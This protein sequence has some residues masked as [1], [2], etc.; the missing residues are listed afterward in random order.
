MPPNPGMLDRNIP[1]RVGWLQN[2]LSPTFLPPTVTGPLDATTAATMIASSRNTDAL[3]SRV[4]EASRRVMRPVLANLTP[5]QVR[6]IDASTVEFIEGRKSLNDLLAE[7]PVLAGEAEQHWEATRARSQQIQA[8]LEER[9]MVHPL[10]ITEPGGGKETLDFVREVKRSRAYLM[11]PYYAHTL[12]SGAWAKYVKR[13][14]KEYNTLVDRYVNEVVKPKQAAG[15]NPLDRDAMKAIAERELDAVLRDPDALAEKFNVEIRRG[16]KK[17]D[18]TNAL[19][20]K[21]GQGLEEALVIMG[22]RSESWTAAQKD[23]AYRFVAGSADEKELGRAF[24]GGPAGTEKDIQFLRETRERADSSLPGWLKMALGPIESPITRASFTAEAQEELLMRS[25]AL[26]TLVKAGAVL[27]QDVLA[28][29]RPSALNGAEA[30]RWIKIP[31]NRRLYGNHA[32][33][34]VHPAY[35]G[36]LYYDEAR[37]GMQNLV[38]RVL[39]PLARKWKVAQTV[40]S[41]GSWLVNVMGNL[42]GMAMS[43]TM[44]LHDIL[45]P[46]G[47]PASFVDSIAQWRDF[48]HAPNKLSTPEQRS[49]A[50]WIRDSIKYGVMSSDFVSA[51]FKQVLDKWARMSFPGERAPT[52][53]VDYLLAMADAV[54]GVSTKA[55]KTYGAIDPF[56]KHVNWLNGVRRGGVDIKTGQ[57]ADR[58]TAVRFLKGWG[59]DETILRSLSDADLAERVK[60]GNARVIAESHPQ[61]DRM[62][63]AQESIAKVGDVTG[64]LGVVNQFYRT[65][66]EVLRTHMMLP[67]RM[68]ARPGV[69]T[70]VMEYAM[71]AAAMGAG[72]TALKRRMG[73]DPEE[74]RKSF[75]ALPP[76]LRKFKLGA[77]ALPVP[78]DDAGRVT[79]VDL[80]RMFDALKFFNGEVGGRQVLEGLSETP[81]QVMAN[82]AYNM[83]STG[84]GFGNTTDAVVRDFLEDSGLLAPVVDKQAVQPGAAAALDRIWKYAAPG[85]ARTGWKAVM[86]STPSQLNPNPVSPLRSGVEMLTG[87]VVFQGGS[88]RDAAKQNRG[89]MKQEQKLMRPNL[90][91]EG[92]PLGPFQRFDRQKAADQRREQI[93]QI[94]SIRR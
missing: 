74:E 34:Y 89:L 37:D 69:A 33:K 48:T 5:Q 78:K 70:S 7:H 62:G 84:L 80:G 79:Y 46:K 47:A 77:F 51:E 60:A 13:N 92:T 72:M 4:D 40:L 85:F 1:D 67:Y 91:R 26:E 68:M 8:V 75:M 30:E 10:A 21:A 53:T 32:G 23:A 28:I 50:D 93:Q 66:S 2:A 18:G 3:R 9:G 52:T 63:R 90:M 36:F 44:P 11:Q 59:G 81:G 54:K 41:Q 15:N 61:P 49:G 73:V 56:F 86:Q 12:E 16:S 71:L 65:S 58:E 22:K 43:G 82:V 6:N 57:L 19:K 29:S 94:R 45:N 76:A 20:P 27:P 25:E 31:D 83:V 55:L 38:T 88:D 64:P 87:G 24:A 39:A 17:T 35:G 14:E 42:N